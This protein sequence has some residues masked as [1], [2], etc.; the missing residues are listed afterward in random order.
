MHHISARTASTAD[1]D[2]RFCV[3]TSM[4]EVSRRTAVSPNISSSKLSVHP[5]RVRG[6]R[7]HRS[8]KKKLY[9]IKNLMTGKSKQK[10]LVDINLILF[11]VHQE[12]D[13]GISQKNVIN[14]VQL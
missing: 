1:V 6:L 5:S 9:K 13:F 12:M 14:K 10:L 2:N 11:T 3:K 8:D 7:C 4:L